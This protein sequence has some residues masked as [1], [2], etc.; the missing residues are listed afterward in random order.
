[1]E[2]GERQLTE[3]RQVGP[4]SIPDVDVVPQVGPLEKQVEQP[5]GRN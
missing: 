2:Y 5:L 1:V 3:V 4:A